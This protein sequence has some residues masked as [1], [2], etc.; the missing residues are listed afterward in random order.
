MH[1]VSC[2]KCVVVILGVGRPISGRRAIPI[3]IDALGESWSPVTWVILNNRHE[4]KR[5][6]PSAAPMQYR[7]LSCL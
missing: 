3:W 5:Y 4:S 2:K 6:H 7:T 1:P